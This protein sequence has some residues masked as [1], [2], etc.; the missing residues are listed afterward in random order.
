MRTITIKDIYND[1]SYINPSVSTISSIGDYI[2]ESNRQVAQSERNRISEYLPQGSLAHKIITENLN[3]FFSD[4]QLWVIAYELQK[5]EAY[6]TNLSNEIERRE[7]AAERKA[8]ASKAKLSANKEGSQEVLDF[9]KSNKKLLKDYYVFL[10]SN[11]KYSKE[12]YSKKFTFE[13]AK[14]FINKV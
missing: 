8:A 7:Q 4:K 9:V 1:V 2:E 5:N 12:F 11:K 10:K 6:V 13:S 3:D 14:E